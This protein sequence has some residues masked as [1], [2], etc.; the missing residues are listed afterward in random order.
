MESDDEPPE[1][2]DTDDRPLVTARRR[3][4]AVHAQ[5]APA[6]PGVE[7]IRRVQAIVYAPVKDESE[8]GEDVLALGVESGGLFDSGVSPLGD[9]AAPP[10][11]PSD[12]RPRTKSGRVV[13]RVPPPVHSGR[14]H[15]Y[16]DVDALS[17]EDENATDMGED[18]DA[19]DALDGDYADD[20]ARPRGRSA[21]RRS[22][23][24]RRSRPAVQEGGEDELLLRS[25]V[26]VRDL[27][28]P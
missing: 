19:D 13:K 3:A 14:A 7:V 4:S 22:N 12:T 10:P 18:D 20:A 11:P 17:D 2:A 5:L 8:D 15:A 23:S 1:A 16:H 27:D 28:L 21:N 25:D 26:E 6:R 9:F 24:A